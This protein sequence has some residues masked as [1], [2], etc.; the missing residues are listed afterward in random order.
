MDKTAKTLS[1]LINL[2][3]FLYFL[4]LLIERILSV[5]LSLTNGVS[6]YGDGY[7]GYTYTLVFLSAIGWLIY[8]ITFC[9]PNIKALFQFDEKIDFTHLCTASGIL[10]LSGMVHTEHTIPV[11]QFVSFGILII[12][13]LLKVVI[14]QKASQNKV[15]LWLSFAF[16][17]AMS[18]AIP[19]MYRSLIELH[20]LFHA[21]EGIASFVLVGTFTYLL[22]QV[23]QGKEDLFLPWAALLLVLLDVPLIVMR[24]NEEINWFVLI[25]LSLSIVLFA[26]GYLYKK[27][28]SKK[29]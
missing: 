18:M 29:A 17:V 27:A 11:I 12:G 8:L 24:W 9:R 13:I 10:L 2:S 3:F 22:L 5:V 1:Y 15:I 4:I 26:V 16:L 23:F 14:N 28:T 19:V 6:L 20:V 7:N 25:F 21:L